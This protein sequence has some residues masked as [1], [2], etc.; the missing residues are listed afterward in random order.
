VDLSP[1]LRVVLRLARRLQTAAWLKRGKAPPD[2]VFASDAG[3]PFDESN[4]A[5]S[6][7][8]GL[9]VPTVSMLCHPAKPMSARPFR[10]HASR[11]RSAARPS[12]PIK[13]QPADCFM[14]AAENVP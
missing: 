3:T 11:V 5:G 9:M 8:P 13:P 2:A 10:I 4:A 14:R 12:S 7:A 1:Q 6:L